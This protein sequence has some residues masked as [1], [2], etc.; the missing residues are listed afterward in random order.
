MADVFGAIS[1]RFFIK[2]SSLNRTVHTNTE[3]FRESCH[4]GKDSTLSVL[5][6]SDIIRKL[7]KHSIAG[8]AT[9]R[10]LNASVGRSRSSEFHHF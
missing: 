6:N 2:W 5:Q 1:T 3:S 7:R 9:G 10:Q 8:L 4:V